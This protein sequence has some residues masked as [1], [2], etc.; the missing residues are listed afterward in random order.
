M[1]GSLKLLSSLL[2]AVAITGCATA[3]ESAPPP[4]DETPEAPV[5]EEKG[6]RFISIGADALGTA[7]MALDEGR[8]GRVL[9][10]LQVT[11]DVAI[12]AYDAEDFGALSELMHARHNRCG[13]FMVHESLEDAEAAIRAK[14]NESLTPLAVS[15]T[16]DN[17]A[18]VNGML[19]QLQEPR[20]KA[21]IDSL[22]AFQNR[23]YTST[24]G[25]QSSNFIYD[26][27]RSI[28]A[29]RSDITVER[30]T[31]TW[32]QSSIVL[33]IPGSTLASEVVVIG[34]HQDSIA[35]GNATSIAPGA[36]DDASGIAT[37][38]E[39]LRAIVAKDYRPLRTVKIMAYAAEEVGLRGS[40][41]IAADYMSRGVNVVGV[42]QFDMTNY[43]GS[44]SDIYLMQDYTNA[45]QNTFV[46][47]LITTYTTATVATDSCGYGCSD[48]ASWHG[49]GIPAS[50][51]FE[52]AMSQYNPN[53]HT[54]NDRISVSGSNANHALKFARLGVAYVAELAKGTLGGGQPGNT[55]PTVAITAPANGST[56]GQSVTLTGTATDTQDG[57]LS[58]TIRWSSS[59]AG[60]LGTGASLAVTLAPG[61]HTLTAA[62]TDSGGLLASTSVSVTV[63]SPGGNAFSDNFE[64]A[65]L[66]WTVAGLWHKVSNSTC[67]SPGYASAVS[68]LYYGQNSTCNYS[69]GARTQ[70]TALSNTPFA[71]SATSSLSFKFYRRVESASGSYDVASVQIVNA[72]G[73][74]TTVWTRSSAN[75]STTTWQ[76]S[77]AI[78][79]S[80]FAGQSVRLQLRFDS[81]DST[82]NNFTG[83]LVDD[84]VVTR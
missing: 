58:S 18:T 42:V 8:R 30:F 25:T 83:W 44:T 15:Y 78:S 20:I 64:G 71:A 43:K 47:N 72:S 26:Q 23:Y 17:A 57:S 46:R 81:V 41:A 70:G 77:G 68:S 32:A 16:I 59:V 62:V 51:P 74:A 28:A 24:Y 14:G 34:G 49:R 29:S 79:L 61:A 76:D 40:A 69:T 6:L 1:Q 66:G 31:H 12:L 80:A 35:P 38:T 37:I 54:S 33:T 45:A 82:A 39:V 73:T 4:S 60:N 50:M 75:A 56:I 52:S 19:P 3:D 2:L 65:T 36:D 48:H 9:T 22:S 7:Q 10:P 84:I 55:A 5:A 53:I 63:S 27:W 67:A 11:G 13:G 21:F